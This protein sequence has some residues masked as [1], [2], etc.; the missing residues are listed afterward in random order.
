M[1]NPIRE[2]I[3]ELLLSTKRHA[4][5]DRVGNVGVSLGTAPL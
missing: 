2:H 3:A 1:G 4:R 5:Y